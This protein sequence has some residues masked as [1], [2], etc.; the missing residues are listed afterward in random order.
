MIV[1]IMLVLL[2]GIT[3]LVQGKMFDD[4]K[5]LDVTV[6]RLRDHVYNEFM[7]N[8]SGHG[9]VIGT[10]T[11]LRAKIERLN[12]KLYELEETMTIKINLKG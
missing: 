3:L 1:D 4:M 12:Q 10:I 11:D 9:T 8:T 5:K 2:V 6:D 7:K